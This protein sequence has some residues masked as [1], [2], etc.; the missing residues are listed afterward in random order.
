MHK[1]LVA[2]AAITAAAAFTAVDDASAQD[3]PTR[4]V[5]IIL[6]YPP[7]GTTDALLRPLTERLTEAL[8]Q[9]V[10]IDYKP[11][12]NG[13]IGTDLAAKAAPD[14]Y[15]LVLGAIGPMAVISAF[16]PL[17]YDP[18]K[19]LA[20]IAYLASVP[21]VLVVNPSLP[22]SSVADVVKLA[23]S[24]PGELTYGSTGNG[25]SN[26]LSAELFNVSAGVRTQQVSYKGGSA[27]Q[28][29]LIGGQ[30]TMMFDNL[31]AALPQIRGGKFKPLAVTSLKRQTQLPDV[32]TMAEVGFPNFEASSWYG[33]FA[34]AGT[35]RAIIDRL[36]AVIVKAIETP[37]LRDRYLS[38]GYVLNPGTPEAL[39]GFVKA[40]TEKWHRVIGQA[41][42]KGQ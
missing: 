5:R 4:P 11:G 41:G 9:S 40:E 13:V 17:P 3:Y 12:A 19:D 27:A 28:I 6:P 21:N 29:D 20:A 30:I 16:Q 24:K 35:P 1:F 37:A 26:Q 42:I 32:P 14:G 8:G 7:G 15:T 38:M 25:S 10:L 31:P 23:K 33:M 22:V 39:T 2:I 36:N 18:A 34:P